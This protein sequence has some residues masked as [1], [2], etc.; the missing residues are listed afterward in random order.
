MS[1][2]EPTRLLEIGVVSSDRLEDYFHKV[3][4]HVTPVPTLRERRRKNGQYEAFD[5]P[6][7]AVCIVSME[8]RFVKR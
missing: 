5:P 6:K 2:S 8:T 1:S 4:V 7:L 3:R